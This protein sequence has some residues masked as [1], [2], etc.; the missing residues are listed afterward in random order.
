MFQN[1]QDSTILNG[2][3]RPRRLAEGLELINLATDKSITDTDKSILIV[4]YIQVIYVLSFL[5]KH[6][7]Q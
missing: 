7:F 6:F 1:Q 3:G 4:L 2:V 5:L